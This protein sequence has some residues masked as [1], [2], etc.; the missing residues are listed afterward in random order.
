MTASAP[1][2]LVCIGLV[3]TAAGASLLQQFGPF[4]ANGIIAQADVVDRRVERVHHDEQS[5][6]EYFVTLRYDFEGEVLS[7]EVAVPFGAYDKLAESATQMI[8]VLGGNPSQI[9][10]FVGRNFTV[11]QWV[12][13]LGLVLSVAG[14]VALWWTFAHVRSAMA[15]RDFGEIETVRV[16]GIGHNSEAYWLRWRD[17]TGAVRKSI[18]ST[19]SRRYDAYP[20]G[21]EISVFRD[22]RGKTWWVGD[23]GPRANSPTV[24]DEGKPTS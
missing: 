11:G 4:E 13:R 5:V 2:T 14:L 6:T 3:L 9:E 8:H 17:V 19:S 10:V 15:A 1:I 20:T 16:E 24:P 7:T 23:V 12:L 18:S 21:T 22:S